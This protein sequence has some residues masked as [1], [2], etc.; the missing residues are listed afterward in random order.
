MMRPGRVNGGV[1]MGVAV[2]SLTGLVAWVC[3]DSR[4]CLAGGILVAAWIGW[5]GVRRQP[6]WFGSWHHPRIIEQ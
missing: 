2:P 6:G 3:G 1:S 5:V 4:V